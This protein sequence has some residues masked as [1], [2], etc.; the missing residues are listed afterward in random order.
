MIHRFRKYF[1]Y[2]FFLGVTYYMLWIFDPVLGSIYD[3][4]SSQNPRLTYQ[5]IDLQ[6]Q[7]L[8]PTVFKNL[9]PEIQARFSTEEEKECYQKKKHSMYDDF[10]VYQIPWFKRYQYAVADYRFRDFMSG[11]EFFINTSGIPHLAK[12]QY[13]ILDK[14]LLY[15]ILDLHLALKNKGLEADQIGINSGF[16]TPFYNE[17]VGG[18]VCSRHQ[19]GDAVDIYVYDINNDFHANETDTQIIFDLLEKEVIAAE[20]GLGKYSWSTQVLHFDTRGYRAR[21]KY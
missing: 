15:K 21:W 6:L 5:D 20:G 18:K 9:S 2:L 12:T 14:K 11:S 4:M 10:V 3:V 1:F 16:R 17:A 13:L 7:Q 8:N 19:M